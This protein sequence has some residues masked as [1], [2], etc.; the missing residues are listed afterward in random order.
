ME[1]PRLSPPRQPRRGEIWL[2]RLHFDPLNKKRPLLIVSDDGRNL[3]PRSEHV[4][5]VPLTSHVRPGI[6]TQL[7]LPP[8]ETGLDLP[9]AARAEAITVVI[10]SSLEEPS[11]PTRKLSDR[12]VREVAKRVV[13][14]MGFVDVSD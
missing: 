12:R 14:A 1:G 2:G 4:L 11:P 7:E 5:C 9:S 6:R 3:N 10:K 13:L 8:G